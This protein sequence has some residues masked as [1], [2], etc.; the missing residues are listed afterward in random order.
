M[1]SILHTKVNTHPVVCILSFNLDIRMI[2][3]LQKLVL[4]ENNLLDQFSATNPTTIQK[5]K[6]HDSYHFDGI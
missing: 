4:E 6:I 1:I 2:L 3:F 5:E